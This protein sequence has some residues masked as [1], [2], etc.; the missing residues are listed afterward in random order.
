MAIVVNLS[1]GHTL[2]FDLED[3][4]AHEGWEHLKRTRMGDI[5]GLA[6]LHGGVTHAIPLKNTRF[7]K[8]IV[9]A[10]LV[11]KRGNGTVV[12]ERIRVHAD[13]VMVSLLVY[14]SGS[15]PTVRY[16]IRREGRPVFL[17]EG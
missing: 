17:A 10:E 9:E 3:R 13:D 6:I 4:E 1:T 12:G 7:N 15:P 16:E 8:L 5:T 2:S 14:R 11:M